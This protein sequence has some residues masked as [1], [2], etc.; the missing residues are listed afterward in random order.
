MIPY[1]EALNLINSQPELS[2]IKAVPIEDLGINEIV[3]EDV[4]AKI[5]SPPFDN[6]A[7]DGYAVVREKAKRGPLKA[8]KSIFATKSSD[9]SI[10]DGEQYCAPI[11]T[12]APLPPWADAVIPL[13]DA[14]EKNGV[15]H[16]SNIPE[17]GAFV[18]RRGEDA[19]K[20]H[21]LF[22]TGTILT[23]ELVMI[24]ASF[25]YSS[26]KIYQKPNITLFS[27]G[28]ELVKPGENLPFGGIYNSTAP[29]LLQAFKKMGFSVCESLTLGDNKEEASKQIEALARD[30]QTL[31]VTTGAVSAGEKDFIPSLAKQLGFKELF[32]KVAIKPGK[33]IFLAKRNEEYWLG[34][35]GNAISTCVGWHFFAKPLLRRLTRQ[36]ES[37][38]APM[39]VTLKNNV[40]KPEHLLCFYRA[41]L[42]G[43]RTKAWVSGAQQSSRLAASISAE[44]Y[45]MLPAGKSLFK[46]GSKVSATIINENS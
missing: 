3:A 14:E 46:S 30:E 23:P 19:K 15:V 10:A 36:P 24:A 9:P 22:S 5:D 6:S 44:A 11:M 28:D 25:G 35:P 20:G 8:G 21:L 1:E 18:R 27:T 41:E 29:Y 17:G 45:V 13:E 7:M 37:K 38:K 43:S 31:I 16:F 39:T 12:G 26:L 42:N 4:Y 33:P 32:H 2:R 40:T 34:L